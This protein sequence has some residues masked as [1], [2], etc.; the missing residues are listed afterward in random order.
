MSFTSFAIFAQQQ[1]T[2]T[3]TVKDVNG[4]S[5][6]GANISVKGTTIGT[7]TDIN[8]NFKLQVPDNGKL[9]ISYIGYESQEI[10]INNKPS[11]IIILKEDSKML[12]E[13]VVTAWVLRERKKH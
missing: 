5:V 12:S 10:S 4:E 13:V 7:I 11:F 8:G 2:I 1:I 3:G 6:I 9:T